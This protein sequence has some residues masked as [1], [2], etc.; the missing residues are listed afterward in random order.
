MCRLLGI[1][2]LER[3]RFAPFLLPGAESLPALSAAQPGGWGVAYTD[4]MKLGWSLRKVPLAASDASFSAMASDTWGTALVAHVSP[5]DS[6]P[7][8]VEGM[9]PLRRG[10]W[11]FAYAGAVLDTA[12]L[13]GRTSSER[14]RECEASTQADHLLGYLLTRLD[15]AGVGGDTPTPRVDTAVEALTSTLI[16]RRC[17]T[18][19]FLLCNGHVL[20]ACRFEGPLYLA[21]RSGNAPAVAVASEPLTNEAWQQL[22]AHTLLRCERAATLDTIILRGVDPRT[23]RDFSDVEL[24]FTD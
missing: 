14:L 12:F 1:L 18:G 5:R 21:E 9:Q 17:A 10:R 16:E 2:A 13:N 8:T 11:V 19:S 23:R 15:E 22:D 20:Y 4:G 24:P 6:T 7:V 3:T